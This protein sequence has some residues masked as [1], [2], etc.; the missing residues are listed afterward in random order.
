MKKITLF[1][2]L[3]FVTSTYAQVVDGGYYRLKNNFTADG[4]IYLSHDGAPDG[5]TKAISAPAA[6]DNTPTDPTVFQFVEIGTSGNYDIVISTGDYNLRA[7]NTTAIE[8][9]AWNGSGSTSNPEIWTVVE[10]PSTPGVYNIFTPTTSS[11]RYLV[12][13]ALSSSNPGVIG[14][15]GSDFTRTQWIIEPPV[16]STADLDESSVFVSNPIFSSIEIKGLTRN[17]SKVEVFNLVGRSLFVEN[18]KG[19]S[20]VSIDASALSSGIYLLKFYGE[21]FEFTKKIIKR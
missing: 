11:P 7:N 14:Y 13:N 16:L 10:S 21:T 1:L 17:V 20:S 9:R 2:C 15:S 12:Y 3:C 5:T 6:G 8:L 4:T 19:N 18:T